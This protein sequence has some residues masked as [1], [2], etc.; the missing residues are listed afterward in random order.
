[1]VK[2][3]YCLLGIF[4]VLLAVLGII[5]PLLPTTPFLLLALM[6]FSKSSDKLYLWL[7]NHKILGKYI[8]NWERHRVIPLSAKLLATA[9]ISTS[10]FIL[11]YSGT[12]EFSV[13]AALSACLLIVLAYLWRF[14][15]K[16][17]GAAPLDRTG[18]ERLPE[19]E[20]RCK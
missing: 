12:I 15:S 8:Y 11:L 14:P 13:A 3:V 17:Q 18:R 4:F 10:S 5:L 9:M 7:I 16:V 1:M 19:T 2:I 6:C 20:L